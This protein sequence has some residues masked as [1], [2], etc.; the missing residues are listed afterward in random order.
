MPNAIYIGADA[1]ETP[2]EF[3]RHMLRN[4]FGRNQGI[5]GYDDFGI[6]LGGSR[7]IEITPGAA[8]ITGRENANQGSYFAYSTANEPGPTIPPPAASTRH[9][10]LVLV[11]RDPQYSSGIIPGSEFQWV[12]G[13]AGSGVGPT[14]A[15]IVTAIGPGASYIPIW[16]YQMDPGD[17]TT[18]NSSRF[19][20]AY[21]HMSLVANGI[22]VRAKVADLPVSGVKTF[23]EAWTFDGVR[24]KPRKWVWSGISW[25][26]VLTEEADGGRVVCDVV[27]SGLALGLNPGG[28]TDVC[29]A[30]VTLVQN[31]NYEFHSE[32]GFTDSGNASVGQHD[33]QLLYVGASAVRGN[34]WR[35]HLAP[36]QSCANIY[37]GIYRHTG[38]T[39]TYTIKNTL[40]AASA[41]AGSI[42]ISAG[43]FYVEEKGW[44]A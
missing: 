25:G 44:F 30:S 2:V 1:Y 28:A 42:S 33:R 36:G 3:D 22:L 38:A 31:R 7:T 16:G 23:Q 18:L 34:G 10:N 35:S 41:N 32:I 27:R 13:V 6:V 37:S 8:V 14:D 21:N 5:L 20:R 40:G 39:G 15:A 43:S 17:T 4:V 19:Y 9:D 24:S 11:V 12:Q 26:R 29:S